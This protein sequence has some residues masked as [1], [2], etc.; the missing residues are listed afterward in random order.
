VV[1]KTTVIQ[2][3]TIAADQMP[4]LSV[5]MNVKILRKKEA[6]V[7]VQN[8]GQMHMY[9]MAPAVVTVDILA[10]QMLAS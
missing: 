8:A 1:P 9:S 2:W 5:L 6:T 7:H 4:L 10:N 3:I